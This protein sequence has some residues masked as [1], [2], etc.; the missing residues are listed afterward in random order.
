MEQHVILIH[1][2]DVGNEVKDSSFRN[3]TFLGLCLAGEP[4]ERFAEIVGNFID[5][6]R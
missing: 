1:T 5:F 3:L 6:L 2:F 4:C